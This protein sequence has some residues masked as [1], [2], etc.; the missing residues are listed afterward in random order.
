MVSGQVHTQLLQIS[1]ERAEMAER[2]VKELEREV[3]ELTTSVT[4]E[5]LTL[6]I[7]LHVKSEFALGSLLFITFNEIFTSND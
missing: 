2:K 1:D 6:I 7:N 3:C 5:L 4:G